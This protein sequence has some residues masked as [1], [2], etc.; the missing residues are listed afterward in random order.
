MLIDSIIINMTKGGAN[1][2]PDYSIIIY[3]DGRVTYNGVENVK[4]KGVVET[5][6]EKDKFISLL[7]KFKEIGFFSLKEEYSIEDLQAR[8]YTSISITIPKE[9][10]EIFTKRVKYYQGARNVPNSLKLLE[11]NIDEI[12]GTKKWIEDLS[13]KE[14]FEKKKDTEELK[15]ADVSKTTP[16]IRKKKKPLKLIGF[17]LTFLIVILLIFYAVSSGM[18]D[19]SFENNNSITY[20]NPEIKNLTTT[21]N[22]DD[23][24]DYEESKYFEPGDTVY[25]YQE[26]KNI[27]TNDGKTCDIIIDISVEQNDIV[28]FSN[29]YNENELNE[30]LKIQFST[31]DTWPR[32][33][34]LI[35]VS[36]FDKISDV[37][38]KAQTDFVIVKEL[39]ENLEIT[40]LETASNVRGFQDYDLDSIFYPAETIYIYL[41]Y[42]NITL[43]SSVETNLYLD[44]II[45]S[46]TDTLLH[47]DF[48]Y[49]TE[50]KNNAHY[51]YFTPDENWTTGV[52]TATVGLLDIPTNNYLYK[53]VV[54]SYIKFEF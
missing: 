53:T 54:F 25:I 26:N 34:Y 37:T 39:S 49:K 44:L 40:L 4:V 14:K 41:E 21:K 45:K 3:G 48:I 11:N 10:G 24:N 5:K 30:Y 17:A 27:S 20:D 36:L 19:I 52:Y 46:S 42:Q 1:I 23:F 12:I 7:S 28:Y 51:W 9:N 32:G 33:D 50:I 29:T 47:S 35:K 31:T 2:S 6:I 8:P 38:T 15:D 43:L 16:L 13:G 22:I 18:L